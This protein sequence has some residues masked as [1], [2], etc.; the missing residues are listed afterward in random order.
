MCVA[1]HT[2]F[3]AANGLSPVNPIGRKGDGYSLEEG[4]VA[5]FRVGIAKVLEHAGAVRS[6]PKDVVLLGALVLDEPQFRLLPLDSVFG[7]GVT[8]CHLPAARRSVTPLA[9]LLQSHSLRGVVD[10]EGTVPA[11]V[12]LVF[13]VVD[14][15]GIQVIETFLPGL[16]FGHQRVV[17][18]LLRLADG[19]LR[20]FRTL[21][22]AGIEHQEAGPFHGRL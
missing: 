20:V 12:E 2:D 9:T 8:D 21:D 5:P 4:L 14:H 19:Q 18:A 13:F 1:C 3:R 15:V 7:S 11:L 17:L 16:V 22:D 10:N 6:P